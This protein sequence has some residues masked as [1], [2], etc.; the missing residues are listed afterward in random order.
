[1]I[2]LCTAILSLV[3]VATIFFLIDV[4]LN[5]LPFTLFYFEMRTQE[6]GYTTIQKEK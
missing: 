1:M 4:T 3:K 6:I 2:I 5:I